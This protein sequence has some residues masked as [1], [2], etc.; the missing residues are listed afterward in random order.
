MPKSLS[1]RRLVCAVLLAVPLVGVGCGA[2]G[3]LDIVVVQE[4]LDAG[5]GAEASSLDAPLGAPEASMPGLPGLPGIDAGGLLACGSC[6]QQHCGMQIGACF[7]SSTCLATA[8]CVVTNCLSGGA[9]NLGCITQQCADGGVQSLLDLYGLFTCVGTNCPGCTGALGGL[10]GLG[11][12][13]GAPGA[14]G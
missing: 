3:P 13:G 1:L 14:G 2:R 6:L 11:G 10:G 8:G 12:G 7:Q 4:P 5:A 9:P